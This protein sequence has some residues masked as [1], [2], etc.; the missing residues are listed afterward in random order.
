MGLPDYLLVQT[1]TRIR[2]ATGTDSYGNTTRDYGAGASTKDMAAWL[3][4]DKRQ[5]P[6]AEGRDPEEQLWLLMTND[7]DIEG[8]DRVTATLENGTVTFDVEGPPENV[9]APGTSIYHHTET[10]L[11]AVTG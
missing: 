11:R 9:Y 5:R 4:Q 10:M 2:P 7:S 1:V 3:Q 8:Y 6:L